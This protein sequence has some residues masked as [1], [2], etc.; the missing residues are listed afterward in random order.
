MIP[1]LILL[2]ASLVLGGGVFRWAFRRLAARA[3]RRGEG[4]D[5][6][7]TAIPEWPGVVGLVL[8]RRPRAAWNLAVVVLATLLLATP[9]WLAIG[10]L[11]I[12]AGPAAYG[13][14]LITLPWWLLLTAL[15]AQVCAR[16]VASR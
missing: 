11:V 9:H 14:W 12:A 8:P 4:V 15:P 1:A 5:L 10:Q 13:W 6:A 2:A 16:H 7:D 3:V